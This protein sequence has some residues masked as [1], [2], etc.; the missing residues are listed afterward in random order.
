MKNKLFRDKQ[1]EL[2]FDLF[3]K[4]LCPENEKYSIKHLFFLKV[5]N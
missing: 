3:F 2:Y 4:E 5:F 1:E